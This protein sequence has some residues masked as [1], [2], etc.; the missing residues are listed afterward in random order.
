MGNP[1]V[2]LYGESLERDQLRKRVGNPDQVAG[3]R[4]V[5][6]A[7]GPARPMRAAHFHT[8]TGLEFTV[9]LDR[10]LDISEAR[11]CGRSLCWRSTTG[12]VAPAYY[13]AEDARWLRS[14]AGGLLTTCGLMNVG[15]AT[16]ESW[17]TGQGVHGRIA[18]TPASDISVTQAWK[19]DAYVLAVSGVMRETRVFGEN[20]SLRRTVS[21]ALGSNRIQIHDTVS[22]EGFADQGYQLLYHCNFGW[23]VVAPGSELVAPSVAMAPRDEAAREGREDWYLMDGPTHD[24]AEKVYYHQMK[25]ADDGIVTCAVLN[26][27]ADPVLRGV[28]LSYGARSLP[29]FTQWK[30]MG[31]QDYVL[32]LEPCNCGV[33]GRERDLEQGALHV[34]RAGEAE[35]FDL[36]FEPLVT[37]EQVTALRDAVGS[38]PTRIVGHSSEFPPSDNAHQARR[39]RSTRQQF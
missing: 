15:T 19:D 1:T 10:A 37:E 7:D 34:L 11:Y 30:Q 32:G 31:E 3:I 6:Y 2:Q 29:R 38:V 9:L 25:A 5:T 26:P 28:R 36:E 23:P 14:F 22:N 8:G 21:T 17:R 18:N 33:E 27:G 13:E 39:P 24:Y 12:D 20:L 35:S 16:A 4:L